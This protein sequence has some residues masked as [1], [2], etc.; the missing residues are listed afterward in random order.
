MTPR[1]TWREWCALTGF[2]ALL[3]TAV[4]WQQFGVAAG[5]ASPLPPARLDLNRAAWHELSA[6]PGLGPGRARAIVDY[7]ERNGRFHS[8]EDLEAVPGVGPVTLREA[9]PYLVAGG[10]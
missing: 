10:E 9:R 8:V 2:L 1:R 5:G 4:A 7:R 6:V 3:A